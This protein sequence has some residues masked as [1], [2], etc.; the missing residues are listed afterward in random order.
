MAKKPHVIGNADEATNPETLPERLAELAQNERLAPLIAAN[1]NTPIETLLGL[2]RENP[3]EFLANPILPLLHLEDPRQLMQIEPLAALTVLRLADVPRWLS[4]AWCQHA[5]EYVL[6]A[7][8]LH[9]GRVDDL[10]S[11]SGPIDAETAMR[12]APLYLMSTKKFSYPSLQLP[13]WVVLCLSR[14]RSTQVRDAVVG[15]DISV[16]LLVRFANQRELRCAVAGNAKTPP[17]ML[18]QLSHD[19]D[20]AV[21]EAVAQNPCTARDTLKNLARSQASQIRAAVAAHASTPVD[22][23][24]LLVE[25]NDPQVRTGVADNPNTPAPLLAMLRNDREWAVREAVAANPNTAVNV[26]RRLANDQDRKVSRMAQAAYDGRQG[27]RPHQT[28]RQITTQLDHR[29]IASILRAAGIRQMCFL[30]YLLM[31]TD[32]ELPA[33]MLAEQ[34]PSLFWPERYLIARHSNADHATLK[35]LAQDG[36]RFVRAVAQERLAAEGG[37]G[38]RHE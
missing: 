27:K 20:A 1:P 22:A 26:L 2:A 11:E 25:D 31:L 4:S 29:Q 15:C 30:E 12:D 6:D 8:W 18:S 19:K 23:L 21:R 37:E 9:V 7:A 5:D 38:S 28:P 32:S 13:D 10:S 14:H 24:T 34:A 3:R 17:N 16:P 35:E 36:N 33:D